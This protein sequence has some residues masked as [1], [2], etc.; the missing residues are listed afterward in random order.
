M[1]HFFYSRILAIALFIIGYVA[2]LESQIKPLL[3]VYGVELVHIQNEDLKSD[4]IYGLEYCF[5]RCENWNIRHNSEFNQD[6]K[7]LSDISLNEVEIKRILFDLYKNRNQGDEIINKK[8]EDFK[9]KTKVNLVVIASL[10]RDISKPLSKEYFLTFKILDLD[11]QVYDKNLI[12]LYLS[13]YELGDNILLR[14]RIEES[15]YKENI[16]YNSK[17]IFD[18]REYKRLIEDFTRPLIQYEYLLPK[19]KEKILTIIRGYRSKNS[20]SNYLYLKE[21]GRFFFELIEEELSIIRDGDLKRLRK[22]QIS[23]LA[24]E[25]IKIYQELLRRTPETDHKS[26]NAIQRYINLLEKIAEELSPTGTKA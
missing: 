6:L 14:S 23:Y 18:P 12:S 4:I 7:N 20:Y 24:K 25:C 10:E 22:N 9:T 11:T 2:P 5:N 15:L 21:K 13:A 1:I 26:R 19:D 8:I 3:V 16:C 17:G